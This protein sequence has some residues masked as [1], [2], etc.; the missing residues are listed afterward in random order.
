MSWPGLSGAPVPE[1][2]HQ[3][4][5]HPISQETPRNS[6]AWGQEPGAETEHPNRDAPSY[7]CCLGSYKGS[8]SSATG[9]GTGLLISQQHRVQQH[10]DSTG[11]KGHLDEG[12]ALWNPEEFSLPIMV[13]GSRA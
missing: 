13:R 9:A 12:A 4:K 2:P 10:S 8:R 11:N 7:F 6:A 3:N 1:S 5:R